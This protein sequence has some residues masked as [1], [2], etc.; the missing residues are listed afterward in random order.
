MENL[1]VVLVTFPSEQVARQIGTTLVEM[2]LIACINCLTSVTS[3]YQW[4]GKLC[5]EQECLGIM[6][7]KTSN[8]SKLEIEINR[9]S[10]YDV[11]EIIALKPEEVSEPYLNW[12][13]KQ[14]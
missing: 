8:W 3:I 4:Q 1:L 10:P 11:T 13:V 14:S 9:L 7:C 2:Q 5:E 12:V 6:K